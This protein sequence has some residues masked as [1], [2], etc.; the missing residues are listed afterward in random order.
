MYRIIIT[1]ALIAIA[2]TSAPGAAQAQTKQ[3]DVIYIAGPH[4]AE[5]L[6]PLISWRRTAY[7]VATATPAATTE[8]L[9]AQIAA[10]GAK[11]AVLVGAPAELP[12]VQATSTLVV[13]GAYQ[14]YD[15]I[16]CLSLAQDGTPLTIV[17][18]IPV[19]SAAELAAYVRKVITTEQA[20]AG[21]ETYAAI[22]D[23]ETTEAGTPTDMH[24]ADAAAEQIA[25][26]VAY[27][28]IQATILSASASNIESVRAA[29]R[30]TLADGAA[31]MLYSGHGA[32]SQWSASGIIN[33]ADA[34]VA[35]GVI[36]LVVE[37]ACETS[38]EVAGSGWGSV[39]R[40]L[41]IAPEGGALTTIGATATVYN[42]YEPTQI[43]PG[44]IAGDIYRA[45]WG[46]AVSREV[47]AADW[48][49]VQAI[50][51]HASYTLYGDPLIT[52]PTDPRPTDPQPV[53]KTHRL[54]M[55]YIAQR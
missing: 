15:C 4:Y 44:S 35:K 17:S 24:F 52:I 11:Y 10:S 55:P 32:Y 31:V 47:S 30:Q 22:I 43:V 36:N 42:D 53:P 25:A 38:R 49:T 7:T 3:I 6:Q 28:D 13:G 45:F 33:Q 8:A 37:L 40:N 50:D 29:A 26:N 54:Y 16:Q 34:R 41:I 39:S 48:T 19:W 14:T 12:G 5:A 21:S 18:R 9:Q 1:L 51:S 2:I 27:Y 46:Q 23:R 20:G